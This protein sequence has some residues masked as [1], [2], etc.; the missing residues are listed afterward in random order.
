LQEKKTT[1]SKI[2]KKSKNFL[3]NDEASSSNTVKKRVKNS[4]E[5]SKEDEVRD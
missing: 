4:T 5:D 1:K 3:D 2:S